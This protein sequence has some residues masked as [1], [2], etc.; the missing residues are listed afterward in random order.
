MAMRVVL[1]VG[2][3][4]GTGW[5][6]CSC[7]NS[8][9]D[10]PRWNQTLGGTKEGAPL[11]Q[12]V[13]D[14]GILQD[15]TTYQPS[16]VPT[17]SG[18]ATGAGKGQA[19]APGSSDAEGQVRTAVSDLVSAIKDREV[20]LAI[21]CFNS[22]H[23]KALSEQH[24]EPLFTTLDLVDQI[25]RRLGANKADRLL[26]GLRGPGDVQI[27]VDM[28]DAD[29]AS[30]TPNVARVLFGSVK[31]SGAMSVVRQP[32]GWKLQFDAPLTEKDVAAITAFHGKLQNSLDQIID[33]LSASK[34][35]N[36]EQLKA[37][38]GQALQG[39]AVQLAP[40]E[41]AGKPESAPVA[42]PEKKAPPE[43][44][45]EPGTPEKP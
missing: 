27:K 34:K 3:T 8:Q 39:E 9:E 31:A 38:V 23:V 13:S 28:L 33:W 20:E 21:K 11:S 22:E 16:K 30:V 18:A 1:L 44:E 26:G 41:G 15:A 14:P 10:A 5:A 32:D 2:L 7:G 35:V 45:S 43:G 40:P 19:A 4:L 42:E 37:A 36:E 12:A 25:A 24:W 17:K 6:L 29:H